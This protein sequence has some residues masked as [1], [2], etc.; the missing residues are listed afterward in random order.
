M[1]GDGTRARRAPRGSPAW[2]GWRGATGRRRFGR[3]ADDGGFSLV[4]LMV[5]LTVIA[6]AM[7]GLVPL[8]VASLVDVTVAHQRQEAVGLGD[9]ALEEVRALPLATVADGLSNTDVSSG[10]DPSIAS[11]GAGLYCYAGEQIPTG[12]N[13]SVVPLVP[14]TQTV[15][16]RK[17]SFTVSVYVTYFGNQPTSNEYRVTAVVSWV[18][19][20]H[21]GAP[22]SVT[23]Q[24]VVASPAGCQSTQTHPYAAPCQPFFYGTASDGGGAV[25]VESEDQPPIPGMNVEQAVLQLAALH[26]N[27]QLEQV[28][29]VNSSATTQGATMIY[30]DATPTATTGGLVTAATAG[31][32][33]SANAPA[34]Q[35][36]TVSQT[37]TTLSATAN[38][39]TLAVGPSSADSGSVAATISASATNVC[40]DTTGTQQV[41]NAPCANAS[42]T[43]AGS[44][45]G[46]TMTLQAGTQSLGVTNL[47]SIGNPSVATF[48][49][50]V[51][52]PSAGASAC[53]TAPAGGV[54]CM[55]TAA[56][57]HLGQ[58]ALAGLPANL[59]AADVPS[60]WAGYLVA[61]SNYSDTATA[62]AGVGAGA[63]SASVT[64]GTIAYWN[65]TGYTMLT[66]GTSAS[67]IPAAAVAISDTKNFAEPL[68]VSIS[69]SLS[70]GGTSTTDAAAGCVSPCTRTKAAG[71]ANSPITGYIDYTVTYGGTPL[72][73]VHMT[74]D[75]G[76]LQASATYQAAP[77]GA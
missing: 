49:D 9:Q 28:T 64:G 53:V 58:V 24:T 34:D 36:G 32:D 41:T 65:G 12:N 18:P 51:F 75:L 57:R 3:G 48:A 42:L 31:N 46:A 39:S 62:E 16:V 54:G 25:T 66:P 63:P 14:H 59:P 73:Q 71:T 11:C 30:N 43:P 23:N 27:S 61:L 5:A 19:A 26:A 22:L 72:A 13:A 56:T 50:T 77:S 37:A 44:A 2:R 69:A 33:A 67:A 1:R 17:T 10:S 38:G 4:E 20:G 70:T 76:E 60:G 6:V 15:T 35:N 68:V 21:V 47:A 55:A 7:A 29:S 40:T 45:A 8:A 52:H 74:V